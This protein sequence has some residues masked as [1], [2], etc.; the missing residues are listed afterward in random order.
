MNLRNNLSIKKYFFIYFPLILQVYKWFH[1]IC[2]DFYWFLNEFRIIPVVFEWLEVNSPSD[3]I[4]FQSQV[5]HR[6]DGMNVK[7][8]KEVKSLRLSD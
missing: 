7:V 5:T 2:Y 8:D 1:M 4:V 3:R 6:I